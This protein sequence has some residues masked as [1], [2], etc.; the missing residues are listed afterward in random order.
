MT[1]L[2]SRPPFRRRRR[3]LLSLSPARSC[4]LRAC[5]VARGLSACAVTAVLHLAPNS[6]RHQSISRYRQRGRG[7][8]HSVAL[9]S[10]AALCPALLHPSC[11]A[12][13]LRGSG[14]WLTLQPALSHRNRSGAIIG[15]LPCCPGALLLRYSTEHRCPEST[16]KSPTSLPMLCLPRG[17]IPQAITRSAGHHSRCSR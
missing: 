14:V 1:H 9:S 10:L 8:W 15:A 16:H 3:P 5:T 13:H 2:L 11:Y 4:F 12:C 7:S 6:S 17:H